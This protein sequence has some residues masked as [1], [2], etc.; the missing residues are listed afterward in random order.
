LAYWLARNAALQ[1]DK[2]LAL[3][4][5]KLAI[6]TGWRGYYTDSHDP[7]LSSIADDPRFKTMVAEVKAGVDRQRA[8]VEAIHPRLDLPALA[9]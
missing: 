9:D 6:D 1:G 4:R 5:L 7:R 2:E 8:E 3:E